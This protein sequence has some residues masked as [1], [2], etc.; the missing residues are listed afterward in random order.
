M[1]K[2]IFILLC[3]ICCS[4]GV[5]SQSVKIGKCDIKVDSLFS[6]EPPWRLNDIN[7]AI[8][9]TPIDKKDSIDIIEKYY[10][11]LPQIFK[12]TIQIISE[13]LELEGDDRLLC[14]PITCNS[15]ISSTFFTGK[16]ELSVQVY[17]LY[18]IWGIYFDYRTTAAWPV[19][20]KDGYKATINGEIVKEAFESYRI[21]FRE[22]KSNLN[23]RKPLDYCNVQW[24]H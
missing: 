17:A 18:L 8:L 14:I 7:G 11:H 1:N 24:L 10:I 20:T 9:M 6:E 22:N 19:L 12:D 13:L 21:W 2:Y 3:S 4:I 5:K 23:K 16:N 15:D